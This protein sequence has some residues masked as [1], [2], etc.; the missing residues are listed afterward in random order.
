MNVV[1]RAGRPLADLW[2]KPRSAGA[3]DPPQLAAMVTGTTLA[4][5]TGRHSAGTR[6][7]HGRKSYDSD[8]EP[9]TE[10]V[11][12]QY[13]S[14]IIVIINSAI[15]ISSSS[16]SSQCARPGSNCSNTARRVA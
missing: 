1:T 3:A 16:S 6:G 12:Q 4:I 2:T 5:V 11:Q 9:D 10:S 13:L 8:I 15:S 14:I 7:T